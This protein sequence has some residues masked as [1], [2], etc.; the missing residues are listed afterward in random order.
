MTQPTVE[1]VLAGVA[2]YD[3]LD[4]SD[5]VVVRAAWDT[6]DTEL[7]AALDFT[8]MCPDCG[9]PYAEPSPSCLGPTPTHLAALTRPSRGAHC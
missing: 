6:R 9:H 8:L 4:E 3:D 5:Q 2:S 1:A 7:L